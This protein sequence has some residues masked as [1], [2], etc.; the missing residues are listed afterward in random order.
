MLDAFPDVDSSG[1]PTGAVTIAF[2]RPDRDEPDYV[3]LERKGVLLLCARLL[4]AKDD[5]RLHRFDGMTTQMCD[6]CLMQGY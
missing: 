1:N 5:Y 6:I 2:C 4:T 3:T